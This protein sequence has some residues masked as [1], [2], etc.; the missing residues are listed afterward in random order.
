MHVALQPAASASRIYQLP[1]QAPRQR[2]AQAPDADEGGPWERWALD[3]LEQGIVV[4]QADGR[5]LHA[6]RCAEGMLASG[7]ALD[8]SSG[9]LMALQPQEL[10]KLREA[11]RSVAERGLCRMLG[12]GS[13]DT[14]QFVALSAISAPGGARLILCLLGQRTLGNPLTLQWYALC[15][16]LTTAEAAVLRLI[17]AGDDPSEIAARQSVAISTVRTQIGSIRAKTGHKS[18]RALLRTLACL[19]SMSGALFG[20]IS[21]AGS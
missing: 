17:C 16:G 15:H 2:A 20:G 11:L 8:A 19:P 12:F 4:L 13:G 7:S 1:P 6:N 21:Q 5:V 14:A 18:I 9:W 10:A 3:R